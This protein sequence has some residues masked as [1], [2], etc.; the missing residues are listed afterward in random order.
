[1]STINIDIA[2]PTGIYFIIERLYARD[3]LIPSF[4]EISPSLTQVHRTVIQLKRKQDMYL[5]GV[6][7]TPKDITLWQQ[8]KYITGSKVTTRDTDIL[9]YTTDFI[10]SLIATTPL[11]NIE[12]KDIPRF[13]T[14]EHVNSLPQAVNFGRD[15]IPQISLYGRKDVV[16]FMENGGKGT[17]TAIAKYNRNMRDLV[18]IKDQLEAGKMMKDLLARGV[19]L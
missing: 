17:P 6:K 4:G 1:M 18:I 13:L 7:I 16:F 11:G 9:V 8:V 5:D 10:G 12:H 3:G 2:R 15:P 19:K 14:T